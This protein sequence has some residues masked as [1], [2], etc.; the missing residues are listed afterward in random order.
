MNSD[1]ASFGEL[2]RRLRTR[3]SFSQEELAERSG[4]S[5][6]GISD[7][8]RGARRA[9]HLQ[10]VRLLAD[11]LRVSEIDRTGLSVAARPPPPLA[12][13]ALPESGQRVRLPHPLTCLVGRE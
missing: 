8:E 11:A 12:S 2:L 9:P 3:A 6:R 7:L 4:L 5:V 1:P 10:T 13:D